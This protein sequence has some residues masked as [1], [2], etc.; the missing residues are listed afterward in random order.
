MAAEFFKF[1][2]TDSPFDKLESVQKEI[3]G[4][5]GDVKDCNKELVRVSK[6]SKT[7]LNSSDIA[8]KIS[9]DF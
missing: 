5:K 4:M 8:K 9:A 2:A 6:E 1:L 7:S 3:S